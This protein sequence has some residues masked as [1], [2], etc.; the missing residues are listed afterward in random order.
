MDIYAPSKATTDS[1]LPIYFFIQGGGFNTNSNPNL[2]G[3]GLVTA[4]DLNIIVITFNYRVGPWGFIAGSEITTANNGLRDIIKA[5]EWVQKYIEQFGGDPKQVVIGGDSA[6]AAAVTL[7]LTSFGGKDQ[8]LFHAAA[9]ESQSFGTILTV[10]ESQYQ[11]D[12]LTHRLD[13]T[14]SDSLACLRSKTSAQIQK[15]NYNLPFPGAKG[16]PLY[17]W[18]PALD[19]DFIRDYSYR[20][21]DEGKFIKVPVIFGDD[22]NGGTIFAPSNTTTLAQSD[23]FL[24]NQFPALTKSDI[25]TINK[26]YPNPNTTCP[27]KGCYWRQCSNA[28][29]EIRYMCP[30]LFLSSAFE[31]HGVNTSW[32]YRYNVEDL[33]QVAQG[34][35]V[36]HTVEINAIWG[37]TNV[38]GAAP[39]SYFKSN[40]AIVPIMQ[41]YWTS[42]I[43]SRNPNTFRHTGSPIWEEWN[44]KN[45]QRLLIELPKPVMENIDSGLQ[46]RCTFLASIGVAIKQ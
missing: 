36:P 41:G 45:N 15:Q 25:D 35:G 2:N 39:K 28:Y 17:W 16:N 33:T 31:R 7:L 26:L 44:Q 34:F 11:Y 40:A 37:P 22:T 29:G 21:F 42:F 24:Q 46:S 6:G 30:G 23:T 3:T 12:A 4:S 13:C 1:K 38:N 9:A 18:G 10:K 32:N 20:A 43:R 8:G 19:N 5:L 14:G 27:H